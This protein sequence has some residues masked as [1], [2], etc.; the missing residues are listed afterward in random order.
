MTVYGGQA[1]EHVLYPGHIGQRLCS[2]RAQKS[3]MKALKMSII[4]VLVFVI[5]WTPYTVMATW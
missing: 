3:V 4:H 2:T 5:S 1:T